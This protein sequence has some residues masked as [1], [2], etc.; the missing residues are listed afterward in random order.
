MSA[1][2]EKLVLRTRGRGALVV[3]K[4]ETMLAP[5]RG[6]SEA[7]PELA[8]G[9]AEQDEAPALAPAEDSVPPSGVATVS[10]NGA[11]TA[12]EPTPT[13]ARPSF[14]PSPSLTPSPRALL[15]AARARAGLTLSNYLARRRR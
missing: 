4:L 1:Y 3:S 9:R 8:T 2:F 10:G 15:A 5:R 14:T 13:T 12:P 7:V 11:V 6:S